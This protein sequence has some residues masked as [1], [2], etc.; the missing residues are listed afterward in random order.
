MAAIDIGTTSAKGLLIQSNGNVLASHQKF[1]ETSFP[2]GGYAEQDPDF[3][4]QSVI[5][6]IK[7]ITLNQKVSG[8]CFSAAMHSL[9]AIDPDGKP[10]TPLII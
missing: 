5:E 7:T 3:I 9:M 10:L 2:Q 4:L 6:I 8:L 1:Y